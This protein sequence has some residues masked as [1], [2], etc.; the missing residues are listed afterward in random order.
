MIDKK[1]LDVVL[2]KIITSEGGYVND[3][4]DR[5]GATK[6]G[7][8]LRTL[9]TVS[10][11]E[12][13]TARDVER[14]SIEAAKKIY[15]DTYLKPYIALSDLTIFNFVVNGGVQHGVRGMNRIIQAAL[16]LTV[17]GVLGTTS[18]SRIKAME[19]AP[20]V[21]LAR[22]VAERCE[23]YADILS[24]DSTQRKFA[25]GWFNRVAKDLR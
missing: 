3:P 15:F 13:A 25:A 5:G 21:F 11:Y 9:Q 1:T 18:W 10:G 19:N 2:D 24:R 12:A 23:Y 22:L 16:G 8:T 7:I 6:Y 4:A 20:A 14:L 17:D